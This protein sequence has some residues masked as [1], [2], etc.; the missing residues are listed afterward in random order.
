[1]PFVNV[2]MWFWF[3]RLTLQECPMHQAAFCFSSQT[4]QRMAQKCGGRILTEEEVGRSPWCF[5]AFAWK[6][7]VKHSANM[8]NITSSLAYPGP[9][10][11]RQH[12]GKAAEAASDRFFNGEVQMLKEKKQY[13][14]ACWCWAGRRW[15]Y[16]HC[17]KSKVKVTQKIAIEIWF[18]IQVIQGIDSN[19]WH[20]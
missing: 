18:R 16:E 15:K 7:W 1:M 6:M 8:K 13:A 3:A 19:G 10:A 12:F 2:Q 14:T 5:C 11:S 17:K 4:P 20:S 9:C